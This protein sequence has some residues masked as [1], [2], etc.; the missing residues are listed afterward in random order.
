MEFAKFDEHERAVE[1]LDTVC[2]IKMKACL[3]RGGG[4]PVPPVSTAT[5]VVQKT[6][7]KCKCIKKLEN[8]L[9]KTERYFATS[10]L[11]EQYSTETVLYKATVPVTSIL[12]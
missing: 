3:Y 11:V 12:D 4:A 8:T 6:A 10:P 1:M 7:G 9:K 2:A 5:A